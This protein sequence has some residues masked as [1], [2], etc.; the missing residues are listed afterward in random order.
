MKDEIPND[1]I[2]LKDLAKITE[3]INWQKEYSNI[4]Q[5]AKRNIYKTY[6]KIGGIGYINKNDAAIPESIHN[7]L[8][9]GFQ[10]VLNQSFTSELKA[11][12]IIDIEL[13]AEETKKCLAFASVIKLYLEYLSKNGKDDSTRE[14]F[15]SLYNHIAFPE[16]HIETGNLGSWKTIERWKKDYL[17]SGNDFRI[18]ASKKNY[19]GSSV[20]PHQAEVLIKLALN[21]NQ[22]LLSEV[23]RMAIDIFEMKRDGR[24]L[25]ENTY[26]RFIDK[27]SKEHYADWV[28]FRE[29]EHALDNK[30][31]PYLERDYDR[32]E[33]GDI[34]VMDGHVNNYEI[35]NPLTGKPKRMMLIGALD[36][37][38]EYLCGYEI[39]PS[40]NTLAIA[41]TIYRAILQ[42]GK[43]PKIIYI[44]NGRAFGAKY[45]HG[46]NLSNIEALFA[47]LGIKVIF[48]QAY[49]AQS[50]IIEPFWGWHAELE[51]LIPTYT[52]TSIEMQPPRMDRGEKLHVKLYEK[53]M[54]GT[55]VDIFTAHKAMAWWLDKYHSRIKESGH[56][57]GLTPAEIF[58]AGKGPGINKKELTFL[59]MPAEITK[60]YRNGIRMFSEWY[61]HESISEKKWDELLIRYD[62]L[63]RGSIFV[64]DKK[65]DFICEAKRVDKVH[66]AAGILGNEEDV[67]ILH[68][69]LERKGSLKKAIV[70]DAKKFLQEEIY[71][72]AK[73]QFDNINIIQLNE[74]T[75]ET[76]SLQENNEKQ[77][78]R[79]RK[80]I[81]DSW[82]MPEDNLNKNIDTISKIA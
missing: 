26:R 51:R 5:R 7:T 57:K 49:H 1:M 63:E 80:N 27:W 3:P 73:K 62:L 16:L 18:F 30:I 61:W 47:R 31:L 29:G 19:K 48:A 59:M 15:I 13:S 82:G 45:F 81:S 44:D 8:L 72:Y 24:I 33:V 67:R 39:S 60:V 37:K 70:G 53:M 6:Q 10:P 50:K 11:S 76:K 46:D 54:T 28:F 17:D 25:S 9:N 65:G 52:G 35:I 34:L 69:Q 21:P 77:K 43:I 36:M 58:N 38:S 2:S 4:R 64:Y 40:E 14:K 56:L 79:K 66:P 68:E 71:P 42:L 74:N 41:I 32:I 23:V 12:K 20:P 55:T 22:P 78:S 75:E